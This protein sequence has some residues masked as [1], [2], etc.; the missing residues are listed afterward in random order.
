M[1]INFFLPL[2]SLAFFLSCGHHPNKKPEN[3]DLANAV[4]ICPMDCEHGKT[5]VEA[6]K[7]PVCGMALEPT[8]PNT[9]ALTGEAASLSTEA[10]QIHDEAMKDLADMNRLARQMKDYMTK[11][12]MTKEMNDEFVTTLA[13]MEKAEADMMSWMAGYKEPETSSAEAVA[14][15]KEQKQKIEQNRNDIRTALETGKKL[16]PE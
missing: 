11:A 1:K 9:S 13:S 3:L 10:E 12:S 2:L 7:C 4:Y 16:M 8:M 15:L 14:Y 5:Y 6:G